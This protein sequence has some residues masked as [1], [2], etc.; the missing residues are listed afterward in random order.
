MNTAFSVI[1][2]DTYFADADINTIIMNCHESFNCMLCLTR[3]LFYHYF[4]NMYYN[5]RNIA[6]KTKKEFKTEF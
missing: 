3:I 5:M 1:K 6:F 4:N 2:H